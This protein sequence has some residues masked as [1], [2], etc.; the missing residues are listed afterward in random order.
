MCPEGIDDELYNLRDDPGEQS[1]VI[2]Q[3]ADVAAALRKALDTFLSTT[4]AR[5]PVHDP[6]YDDAKYQ[7]WL[8]RQRTTVLQQLEAQHA[9]YLNEDWQPNRDWW[10][11]AVTG[12]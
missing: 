8:Q 7:A 3:R 2:A 10:G 1:D 4:G 6:Q 11:S 12:D 5:F 9:G